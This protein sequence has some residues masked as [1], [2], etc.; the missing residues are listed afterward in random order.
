MPPKNYQH[1]EGFAKIKRL[2][3]TIPHNLTSVEYLT[4]L[5]LLLA[6]A[7]HPLL[8]NTRYVDTFITKIL[9]WQSANPK[10]KAASVVRAEL[11]SYV[12]LF[13]VT[14]SPEEKLLLLQKIGFDR[15]IIFEMLRRWLD[16]M[17]QY[18]VVSSAPDLDRVEALRRRQVLLAKA[19]VNEDGYPYGTYHQVQDWYDKACKFKSAILE[20]YTRLCLKTAQTDY[21]KLQCSVDLD[22]ML[23]IYLF[24]ASKAID[25]CDATRGV[26]TTHIQNWLKSARNTVIRSYLQNYK[27]NQ[28]LD[29]EESRQEVQDP[30]GS[31]GTDLRQSSRG[32]LP[33]SGI[34]DMIEATECIRR[35]QQ[36]ARAFDPSGFARMALGIQEFPSDAMRE[37]VAYHN[38]HHYMQKTVNAGTRPTNQDKSHQP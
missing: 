16:I 17:K 19:N 33:S 32:A 36:L 1:S 8:E 15:G 2:Q 4:T 23:Q 21:V 22:D 31:D 28:S 38:A 11:P 25:K 14:I 18:A 3:E 12:T 6:N 7:I 26:L 29:S 27:E 35:V 34:E 24:T 5:D 9:A 20:K 13:L 30:S 37:Q 10:R